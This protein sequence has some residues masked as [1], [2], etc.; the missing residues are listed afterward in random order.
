MYMCKDNDRAKSNFPL[1][2]H[3]QVKLDKKLNAS[4][5]QYLSAPNFSAVYKKDETVLFS[6]LIP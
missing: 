4:E 3:A 5:I 1:D 6:G 2:L